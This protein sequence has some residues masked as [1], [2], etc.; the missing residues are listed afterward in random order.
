VSPVIAKSALQRLKGI[1]Q[2]SRIYNGPSKKEHL[3]K[4]LALMEKHVDE[5]RLLHKKNNPHYHIEVGDLLI[6]CYEILLENQQNVDE[7]AQLC[8]SRYET[9][10][11]KLIKERHAQH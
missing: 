11:K 5:I 7:V 1:H 10:L 9:K 4:L 2:L 8:F 3:E 6:L